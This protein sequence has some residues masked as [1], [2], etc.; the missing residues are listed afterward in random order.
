MDL[1]VRLKTSHVFQGSPKYVILDPG[2]KNEPVVPFVPNYDSEDNPRQAQHWISRIIIHPNEFITNSIELWGISRSIIS[3]ASQNSS[4]DPMQC[5]LKGMLETG[6]RDG[7]VC[8]A[9]DKELWRLGPDGS[10]VFWRVMR[11]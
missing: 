5:C 8:P 11:Q 10:G 4:M 9:V 1:G 3:H 7:P 6:G 2:P